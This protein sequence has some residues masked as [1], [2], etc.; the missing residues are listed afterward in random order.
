MGWT[1]GAEKTGELVSSSVRGAG[2]TNHA[3]SASPEHQS[4]NIAAKLRHLSAHNCHMVMVH[5]FY[6][7]EYTKFLQNTLSSICDI[8]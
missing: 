1:A 8:F 4:E 7:T 6:C 3:S 2:I 5:C